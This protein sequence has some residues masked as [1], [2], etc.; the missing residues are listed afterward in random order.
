[1]KREER[2]ETVLDM[3]RKL[4]AYA[5]AVHGP[6]HAR[7]AAVQT[8]LQKLEVSLLVSMRT[9]QTRALL[10]ALGWLHCA[11]A[12]PAGPFT[13]QRLQHRHGAT[14]RLLAFDSAA[15]R[16]TEA[17][18]GVLLFLGGHGSPPG[19]TQPPGGAREVSLQLPP[20]S[21]SDDGAFVCSVSAPR[22]QVQQVLRLHV[23]A[24]PRVSLL[25]SRL[26]P[27]LPAELHCDA[28][29]FFPL[30]VEIRWEHR[31]HGHTRPHPGDT[32]GDSPV[33]T[34][35]P[36]WSS[37]HRR[38]ADGTFSRSAGLRVA[39]AALGDSYSCLVTHA[40]W[41]TPHRVT[42]VVAG[43]TMPSMEDMAGMALVAF[44]IGGLSLRLWPS[45]GR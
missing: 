3:A 2:D 34:L 41:D 39:V 29:G 18:P 30:D 17:A 7:I 16:R 26:S 13:L 32:S 40:A 4:R 27:G 21:V 8:H 19:T 15:A 22:G 33:I 10:G 44:V 25:P 37:G 24:P 9:P 36:S 42:V 45:V 35:G 5:D 11:F 31:A 12:P 38:A 20:L 6:T 14:R 28:V 23:I 1:M 43:A